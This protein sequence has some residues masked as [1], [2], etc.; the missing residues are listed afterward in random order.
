MGV[1]AE[2]PRTQSRAPRQRTHR[3]R[4]NPHLPAQR[5]PRRP[6]SLACLPHPSRWC[7]RPPHRLAIHHRRTPPTPPQHRTRR[8]APSPRG[9][10]QR[11]ARR[12]AVLDEVSAR[13]Q[14][15]QPSYRR[16][17]CTQRGWS[18]GLKRL[19][20]HIARIVSNVRQVHSAIVDPSVSIANNSSNCY[21]VSNVRAIADN[22]HTVNIVSNA[23][24]V[25]IVSRE[26]IA[27]DAL[28]RVVA[29]I[30]GKEAWARPR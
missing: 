30:N 11:A 22:S 2:P 26:A 13:P 28:Q 19:I 15:A 14:W 27:R 7:S 23:R 8:V 16:L 29:V 9:Q 21:I 5:P 6:R 17:V 12:A 4:A 25:R 10:P 1:V 3:T 18:L 24:R 20:T